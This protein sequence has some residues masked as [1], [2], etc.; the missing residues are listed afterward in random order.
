MTPRPS[1]WQVGV[2]ALRS[3]MSR[4]TVPPHQFQHLVLWFLHVPGQHS[5][6]GPEAGSGGG[7]VGELTLRS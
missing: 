1:Q 3:F 4:K 5:R 2:L 6:A 7:G